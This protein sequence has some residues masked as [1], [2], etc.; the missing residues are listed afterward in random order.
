MNQFEVKVENLPALTKALKQFPQIANP[1]LQ[2]AL[3]GSQFT[4]QQNTLKE[5]PIP[6]RT[7]F[8]LSSF[9]FREFPG[10]AMW[11]PTAYYA[12]YA[13][14]R[15]DRYT[16][17]VRLRVNT[18]SYVT[19]KSGRRYYK[20]SEGS[21]VVTK[22]RLSHF[23]DKIVEKSKPDI[24]KLFTQAGDIIVREIAKQTNN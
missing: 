13:N 3:A 9:R 6:Y 12:A 11:S 7:G 22:P 24:G 20:S 21:R 15:D 8:L 14:D 5:D 2:R 1:V 18:G 19:A 17:P 10:K 23:M 4:F 16:G